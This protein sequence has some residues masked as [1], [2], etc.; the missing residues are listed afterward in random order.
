MAWVEICI[1][2]P[3]EGPFVGSCPSTAPPPLLVYWPVLSYLLHAFDSGLGD[4]AD[5]LATVRIDRTLEKLHY[6]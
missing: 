3:A 5:L 2:W 6:T 4:T 1:L